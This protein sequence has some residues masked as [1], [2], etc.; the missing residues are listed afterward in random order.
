[1]TVQ[2]REAS[3]LLT[4]QALLGEGPIWI[5]DALWFVDIKNQV[6]FRHHPATGK[7]DRW[8]APEFVGW[9][10]PALGDTLIAGLKSGPHRFS[11]ATGMFDRLATVDAEHPANRLNDAAVDP[12]GRL[13]FGTMDNDEARSTGRVFVL[14]RGDLSVVK[15]PACVITNG[16]AI[17]PAGDRLRKKR[18][19]AGR[20]GIRYGAGRAAGA[21][22]PGPEQRG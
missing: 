17:A 21:G 11:P 2:T 18:H 20:V 5:H 10:V 16:P 13:Y 15:V 8:D 4:V 6:I 19:E 1:M 3:H 12:S 22:A 7:I 14:D 9:I